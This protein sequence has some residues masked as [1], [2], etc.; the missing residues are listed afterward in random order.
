MKRHPDSIPARR[1][2]ALAALLGGSLAL[3]LAAQD[4]PAHPDV[5]VEAARAKY[6]PAEWPAG[7]RVAG[8]ALD[9]VTLA[10]LK[11]EE[12]LYIGDGVVTRRFVDGDGVARALVEMQVFDRVADSHAALLH[13]IAYVQSTKTLPTAASRGI[14]AGDIG[15]IGYG[16]RDGSKIAWLAFA[17]GNLDFRVCCLEPDAKGAVD[18]KPFVEQIAAA[19]AAQPALKAGERVPTPAIARFTSATPTVVAGEELL[20]DVAA[21]DP[22]GKPARVD[23]IVGGPGQ[24]QGYVEND[25]QGRPVFHAT[26]PGRTTL[27]LR[28]LGRNGTLATKE[29]VVEVVK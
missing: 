8:F 24:G 16:G 18:V 5:T 10:G 4:A 26:G 13:Q 12:T 22:S 29:L 23:F 9:D 27:T 21:S 1:L 25:D 19:A 17:V 6:H 7:P 3:P 11:G 20:L 15:W 14:A 28:A 2:L